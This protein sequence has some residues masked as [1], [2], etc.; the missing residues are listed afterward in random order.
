MDIFEFAK[1]LDGREYGEE[2]LRKE[3]LMAKELG[4]VV[5]FGCSDDLAELRGAIYDEVDCWDGGEILLD[6]DG[7][8][9]DC[10]CKYG[11]TAKENAKVIEIVWC[12]GEGEYC[13]SYKTD[14]PHAT[15]EIEEDGEKY[16]KGIVFDI[17]SL[18]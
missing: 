12:G 2:I 1:K 14:I 9:E 4:F 13:W 3:E 5:L 17:K 7:I 6:K 15:F 16:C 18:Q 11:R 8:V 10:D